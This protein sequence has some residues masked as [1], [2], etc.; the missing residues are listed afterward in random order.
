MSVFCDCCKVNIGDGCWERH[1]H[2]KWHEQRREKEQK[3]LEENKALKSQMRYDHMWDFLFSV[4]EGENIIF[5]NKDGT[6][7]KFQKIK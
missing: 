5:I 1:I 7:A 2:S 3:E 4:P 6:L